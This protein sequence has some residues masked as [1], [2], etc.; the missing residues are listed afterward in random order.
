[1]SGKSGSQSGSRGRVRVPGYLLH[2]ATGQARVRI[3]G[4]D[5][6]LG[7]YGS[8]ESRERYGRILADLARGGVVDPVEA[9]DKPT[10]VPG[11]TV[12][13]LCVAFLRH[14]QR[15]YVKRGQPTAE[16]HCF[17]SAIRPLKELFGFTAIADFGPLA[18]KAV[19]ARMVEQGW[20]RD[21]V[22]KSVGRLRLIFRWGVENELVPPNVPQALQAV[23]GLQAGRTEAPDRPARR[24]IPS[25]HIEAVRKAVRQRTRD[26]LD[27]LLLT[28]ARPGEL[29]SLT[30]AM[31]DR[32]SDVWVARLSHHKAEHHDKERLL[33][34]GPQ[35]QAILTRYIIRTEPRARLFPVRRDTYGTTIAQACIRA[36]V[37][38]F[39]PHR[40]RHTA[41][42]KLRE[43]FGLEAAQVM[44]GHSK[45]DMTELYA[46][47]NV[48]AA[49]AVAAKIG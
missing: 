45:M 1:M 12:N 2:K 24:P 8:V 17:R 47:K 22:N 21:Y 15:H 7:P 38:R 26:I 28:A 29:L 34:F 46:Q 30:P 40:L 19:R 36:K 6:Y 44:L 10:A 27:L 16:Q 14:A 49:V 13:E 3:Q 35:A 18:L 20:C 4:R 5:V 39:C 31:I 41:A 11:L 33:F 23:A 25:E 48:Q 42:T 37:P 9:R 32:A 43:Q